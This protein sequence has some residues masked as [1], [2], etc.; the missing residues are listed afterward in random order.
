M[1]ESK[2]SSLPSHKST[3]NKGKGIANSP[4]LVDSESSDSPTLSS[5]TN[6]FG[7]FSLKRFGFDDMSG[8]SKKKCKFDVASS[9]DVKAEFWSSSNEALF[10]SLKPKTVVHSRVVDLNLLFSLNCPIKE[11]FEFQGWANLFTTTPKVV[12]EPLVRLFYANLRSPKSGELESLVLGKRIFLDSDIFEEIFDIHCSGFS[13]SLKN[14]W[15]S[16]FDISFEEAKK[17]MVLDPSALCPSSL[18]PKDVSFETRVIAHIVATT[19]LPRAGSF[20]TLTVRDTFFTYCLLFKRRFKLSSYILNFMLDS[21]SDSSSLPYGMIITRILEA[22]HVCLNDVPPIQVKQ[23]YNSRAFGSMGY[24]HSNDSWVLKFD[25]HA[26]VA[27]DIPGDPSPSNP[28]PPFSMDTKVLEDLVAK[29][30]AMDAK[31]EALQD[32]LIA[33]HYKFDQINESLEKVKSVSKEAGTDVA[34]IRLKLDQVI[35]E[36]V[37]VATKIQASS[38]AVTTKISDHF[39]N[40]K[41]ATVNTLSYFL[42]PC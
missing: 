7:S 5:S 42:H 12:Y 27:Q 40:L 32:L 11:L 28:V 20:S 41:T 18:G 24:V 37:K 39:E 3:R 35:K 15:P 8:E 31:F 2:K 21:A 10:Q 34:K 14:S 22:N 33:T 38:D 36:S 26:S 13:V 30:S 23:C 19:L 29:V 25:V 16:D 17:A 9:S 1:A 4:L 6:S